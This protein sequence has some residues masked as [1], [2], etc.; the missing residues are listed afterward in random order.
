MTTATQNE[1][2]R[3][4]EWNDATTEQRSEWLK[5]G[6]MVADEDAD[7]IQAQVDEL[8]GR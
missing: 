5:R 4:T 2:I 1:T 8:S 3:L 7:A 6:V